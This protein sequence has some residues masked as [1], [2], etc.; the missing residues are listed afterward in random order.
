MFN[1]SLSFLIAVLL[2]AG[3]AGLNILAF[4]FF[5]YWQWWWFD[6]FMHST[7]GLAIGLLVNAFTWRADQVVSWWKPLALAGVSALIIGLGWELFEFSLDRAARLEVVVK[8]V[9]TLQ[10]GWYDT[11]TDL[12]AGFIG[13]VVGGALT[14][15]QLKNNVPTQS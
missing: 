2:L 5:W 11:I 10:L 12:L 13:A 9:K 7:G 1:R 6:L 4:R 3:L 8:S 15:W 14:S